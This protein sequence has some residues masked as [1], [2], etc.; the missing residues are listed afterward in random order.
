[1]ITIEKAKQLLLQSTKGL[2]V[3][4]NVV[5]IEMIEAD[6]INQA[7]FGILIE[8]KLDL[9]KF[10]YPKNHAENIISYTESFTKAAMNLYPNQYTAGLAIIG[11]N[12]IHS[13]LQWEGMWDFLKEYFQTNLGFCIDDI[14]EEQKKAINP[15]LF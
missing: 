4:N 5:T 7:C 13:N 15:P 6:V 9:H 3:N 2:K 1:V 12:A 8:F 11:T 10:S 14:L